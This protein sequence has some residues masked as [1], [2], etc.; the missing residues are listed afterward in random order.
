MLNITKEDIKNIPAKDN[1]SFFVEKADIIFTLSFLK[2][3]SFAQLID[4]FAIDYPNREKRHEVTYLL[5]NLK[6]NKR[7][8]IKVNISEQ[9]SIPSAIEIF[10]TANWLERELY[11]MHGINFANHPD[12]RRILTDYGFEGHPMLKDF[13]LTG[14]KEVRYDIESKQVV[15]EPV[16]LTQEYRTFDFLSPWEGTEYKKD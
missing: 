2:E 11:D 6:L 16:N 7:I 4:V 15:Y 9:E 10:R 13:P 1:R 12:L 8:T 3:E 14:Y 5:L